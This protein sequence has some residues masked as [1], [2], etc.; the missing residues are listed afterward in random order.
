MKKAADFRKINENYNKELTEKKKEIFQQIIQWRDECI[1]EITEYANQQKKIVSEEC[2]K[3]KSSL[4]RYF[5]MLTTNAVPQEKE[6]D[7]E[8]LQTLFDQCE[9]LKIEL[10]KLTKFDHSMSYIQVVPCDPLLRDNKNVENT[11][12]DSITNNDNDAENSA[13][14]NRKSIQEPIPAR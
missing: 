13:N 9:R 3:Q 5:K 14:E 7:G 10:A 6:A 8:L 2:E 4:Q 11:P 12:D 1:R